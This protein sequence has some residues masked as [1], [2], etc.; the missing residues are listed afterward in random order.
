MNASTFW[1]M[2]SLTNQPTVQVQDLWSFSSRRE[3]ETIQTGELVTCRTSEASV[4]VSSSKWDF[5]V[6]SRLDSAW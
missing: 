2:S 4:S 5:S 1:G 3:P 6:L